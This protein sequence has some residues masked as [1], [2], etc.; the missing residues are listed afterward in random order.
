[1]PHAQHAGGKQECGNEQQA[2]QV[3]EHLRIM[4]SRAVKVVGRAPMLPA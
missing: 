4:V 2:Q 3:T 1:M